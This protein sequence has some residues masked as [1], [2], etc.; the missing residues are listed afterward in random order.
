M[1]KF[2]QKKVLV[3]AWQWSPPSLLRAGVLAEWLQ[4]RGIGFSVEGGLNLKTR[5]R[6]QGASG[7]LALEPGDWI[8]RDPNGQVLVCKPDAF[9]EV[10]TPAEPEA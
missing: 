6:V 7:V 9:E 8:V 1:A 2:V 10:Y 3:E 5:L 4:N